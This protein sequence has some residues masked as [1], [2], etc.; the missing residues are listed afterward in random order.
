MVSRSAHRVALLLAAAVALL[1]VPAAAAGLG[2]KPHEAAGMAELDYA[3]M[4]ATAEGELE[5]MKR[6][7]E[8]GAN[9]NAKN[10]EGETPLH[11]SG[12]WGK[13]EPLQL[14][15]D[16]GASVNAQ[17]TGEKSLGLAPLHWFTHPGCESVC[18]RVR[19]SIV[20]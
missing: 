1:G 15:L 20:R 8:A 13:L 12:I 17:A 16:K 4:D 7:L 5:E 11:V 2:S 14:L 10:T 6:L 9:V 18:Q 3:L 19:R